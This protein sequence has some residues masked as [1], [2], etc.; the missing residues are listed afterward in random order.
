MKMTVYCRMGNPGQEVYRFTLPWE[1]ALPEEKDVR[2]E[3]PFLDSSLLQYLKASRGTAGGD[4]TGLS[5]ADGLLTVDVVPFTNRSDFTLKIGDTLVPK[6]AFEDFVTEGLDL[7]SAHEEGEVLYRLYSPR[8][9]GPRPLILFL[10]GGGN[11]GPKDGRDNEKQLVADYGPI[12][13]ALNYPDV[14]VLAPQAIEA[15]FDPK[16]MGAFRR[17]TFAQNINRSDG[18]C[19]DYLS[20]IID[21]IRRMVKDGKV[22]EKR[23][24]VTGL[25]MGGAGTIRAMSVGADLFAACAPVCPTM[26]QETFDILRTMKAPVWVSSAYVDHTVYRHKY[27]V[28]AVIQLKDEG[29]PNAHLTLY[30]PEELAEYDI[31]IVPDLPYPEL[32][33]ANHASW[34]LTYHD[35]HGIM[36][37][38]LNQHR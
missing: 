21:I 23:I 35:K 12:N 25:S 7:F 32:F 4:V 19:R 11:G 22:D 36:S 10:H 24:Y 31:G 33:S 38:L 8:A 9:A 20:K 28:D 6:S 14:F 17:Q 26:T 3:G 13:F 16:R 30:S 5:L 29:H 1:G 2:V 37:W 18:W 15:P 34:V 27:L